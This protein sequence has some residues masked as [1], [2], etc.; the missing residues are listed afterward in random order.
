MIVMDFMQVSIV[1]IVNMISMLNSCMTTSRRMIVVV[2]GVSFVFHVILPFSFFF[3]VVQSIQ[4]KVSD[5]VI[6]E[7]IIDVLSLPALCDYP[8]MF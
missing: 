5:M 7:G 2:I 3:C 6:R 8:A 4:N 1:D